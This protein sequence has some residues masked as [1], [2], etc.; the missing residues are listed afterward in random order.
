[1]CLRPCAP[2]TGPSSS[3]ASL[4]TWMASRANSFLRSR[5]P[6]ILDPPQVKQDTESDDSP[7]G[8]TATTQAVS[9]LV[10]VWDT[11]AVLVGAFRFL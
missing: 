9:G 8:V 3:S 1:M 5:N 4:G 2:A 6:A 11:V 7:M 10:G